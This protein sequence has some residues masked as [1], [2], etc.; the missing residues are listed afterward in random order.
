M[1]KHFID[2]FL[3]FVMLILP[4]YNSVI[5]SKLKKEIEEKREDK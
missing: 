4:I 1:A 5:L 3:V 2:V